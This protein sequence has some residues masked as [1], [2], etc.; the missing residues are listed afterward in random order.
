LEN[1]EVDAF[2][3]GF[4]G[5]KGV[6]WW[7]TGCESEGKDGVAL[8]ARCAYAR[9]I[10]YLKIRSDSAFKSRDGHCSTNNAGMADLAEHACLHCGF[11]HPHVYSPREKN[12]HRATELSHEMRPGPQEETETGPKREKFD[13]YG[14]CSRSHQGQYPNL[15]T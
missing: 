1:N 13:P 11:V 9:G 7:T 15:E 2:A 12:I 5:C 8:R 6:H 3:E 10:V 14:G 4:E